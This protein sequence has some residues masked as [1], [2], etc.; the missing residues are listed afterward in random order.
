[1]RTPLVLVILGSLALTTPA[2]AQKTEDEARLIFTMGLTYTGS[3]DLWTV[4]G[5]PVL[6]PGT[7]FDLIDLG[8]EINGSIGLLFSG[9]YFPKPKLG[10]AGEV[11]FM[12]IGIQDQCVTVSPN[13][14]A[15]TQQL[16]SSINGDSK[17]S[18]AVLMTVGPVLRAGA[19]A[20]WRAALGG[21]AGARQGAGQYGCRRPS[22]G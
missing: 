20:G 21:Q 9:M 7:G 5:Q 19:A 1:M 15:R 8:R 17:S 4:Q 11:F 22:P 18:S 3:T 16:C 13:P 2:V 10:L 12:G 6:V 14:N